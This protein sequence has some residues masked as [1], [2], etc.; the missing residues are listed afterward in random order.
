MITYESL[1]QALGNMLKGR[2]PDVKIY[3]NDTTEGWSKP[4]YFLEC[5]P[6]GTEYQTRN[7][8]KRSC[9]IK[10]T[11]FQKA[12]DE[13]DQLR[14]S[15]EIR[16]ML[17]MKFS[18]EGRKLDIKKYTHEYIGEYNNI[19][20]ISFELDWFENT[21]REPEAEKMQEISLEIGGNGKGS[22]IN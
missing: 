7:L 6:F 14:K 18:V 11:Y 8:L 15:E 9:S 12:P 3:G 5:V 19:L 4:Y 13:P 1:I 16:E 2:Y 21:C 20:Q 10:I 22:T 17:G